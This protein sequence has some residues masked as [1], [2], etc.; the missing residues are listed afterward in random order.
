[1]VKEMVK[2]YKKIFWL[3]FLLVI[4]S[5]FY[6]RVKA[7]ELLPSRIIDFAG[8]NTVQPVQ[9]K[10]CNIMDSIETGKK[11]LIASVPLKFVERT[12]TQKLKKGQRTTY[13]LIRRQVELAILDKNNCDVFTERYWLNED[14]VNSANSLRRTYQDNPGNIPYFMPADSQNDYTVLV[15]WWN[16]HNSDLGIVKAGTQE[17]GRYVVVTNKFL[18]SNDDLAYPEDRTGQ[19]YSDVVYVPYSDGIH[20]QE[21]VTAGKTFLNDKVAEAYR[22]LDESGVN[23]H[24]YSSS[25]VT[26]IISQTFIKTLFLTEQTDPARIFASDDNGRRLA[27]RVFVR[28]GANKDKTFRYTYSKTGALGLGQIMP[29]TYEG[30]RRGNSDAGLIRDIDIGRV[31]VVNGIKASVLVVDSKLAEILGM[32]NRSTANAKNIFNS[33]ND[34]QIEEVVAAAYNGGSSKYKPLSGTISLAIRE[35]VDFVRKFKM[36]RDLGLFQ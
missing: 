31:D 34:N 10:E 32:V 14:D 25:N 29:G 12:Q 13:Q 15:N 30:I 33:K 26:D 17:F 22:E 8:A 19:R 36:I 5:L 6:V 23:S 20:S 7:G 27:E 3:V 35:T 11:L 24:A 21:M 9:A 18:I 4:L 1:M 16:N 28:L 2:T